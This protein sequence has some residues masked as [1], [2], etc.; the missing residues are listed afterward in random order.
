MTD[1][2]RNRFHLFS[3]VHGNA[4]TVELLVTLEKEAKIPFL[5]EKAGHELGGIGNDRRKQKSFEQERA[6]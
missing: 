3:A 2:N 5:L 4:F 1:E 6:A